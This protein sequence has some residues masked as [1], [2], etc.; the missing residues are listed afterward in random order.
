[1]S[2]RPLSIKPAT[3]AAMAD[4]VS[5]LILAASNDVSIGREA[6]NAGQPNAQVGY[7]MAAEPQIRAALALIEAAKV[8]NQTVR[9]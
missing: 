5:A 7:L 3:I 1:M 4:Q 9:S 2:A 6:A 8:L